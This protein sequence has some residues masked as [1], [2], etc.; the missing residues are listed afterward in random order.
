MK[1]LFLLLLIITATCYLT[2]AQTKKA[3]K[4]DTSKNKNPSLTDSV[5]VKFPL[6]LNTANFSRIDSADMNL[7]PAVPIEKYGFVDTADLKMTRCDFEKDANAMVLFDRGEMAL[8]APEIILERQ[9]RVKVFNDNGKGEANIHI[10]L[11]NRFGTETILEIEGETINLENGKIRYTKLD[12]KLIYAEH[13][14]KNKDVITF[15]LPDVKAGSVFEYRYMWARNFSRNFPPWNFQC[16]LP[17]RYSQLDAFINPMLTFSVY[18]N[19]ANVFVRDTVSMGGFGHVWAMANIPSTRDEAY[20]RSA[21]DVLQNL[22]FI[23]SAVK[24]NGQTVNIDQSWSDVG[25]EIAADKD[26]YKPYDQSLHD[27][28][29]LVK[30]A[31]ALKSDDQKIA[32]L[33]N[34]VKTVM[35]YN[36][37]KNWMSKD[38]IKAAWKRKSGSWGEINMILNRLLNL[39]GV[40]AYPMLV[41]T[42]D[43]GKI[44]SNFTNIYQINKLVSYV[45]VDSTKYYVL[46]ATDKYNVYNEVPFDLLNSYGLYLNKPKNEYPLVFMKNGAQVRQAVFINADINPDG[47]M[48]GTAQISSFSYHKGTRL[49]LHKMLDEE[50][51]KQYLTENDN[52]LKITSLQLED[53]EVD[54]LPLMQNVNFKLDLPGTDD[55]YIYFNP[56]LF[57][58]L[59]SNPF[60][61]KERVSDI[62]FGCSNIYTINGRYKMPAGYKIDAMP[63][64]ET[65]VM[66]DRSI[67]FK[68]IIGEQ[69]GY[70]VVN[71]V[72][73]YKK[74]LYSHADYADIYAYF[75]Q[76]TEMLNEQIVFKKI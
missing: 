32:F 75:K 13:T 70:I 73:N 17:T 47:T 45:P 9:R 25:R 49:E 59:H 35:K 51:Y 39:A 8:T 69:D 40:K 24:V 68:R 6:K 4:T 15:S 20:M 34:Q 14:D 62:D 1:R 21:A 2:T 3:P 50:K 26:F 38:G 60:L 76:M 41:S 37:L 16:N 52:N 64:M 61:S 23:I 31:A 7:N 72:I 54:S 58:S 29:D 57:T 36:D 46:D 19:T 18:Q 44:L 10:E 63:K 11:N 48:N 56:N 30:K 55:K 12:P 71:Y 53:A 67:I 5:N 65:L 74:S 33:F 28:D 43:N 42:R 27:E 66:H 22:T